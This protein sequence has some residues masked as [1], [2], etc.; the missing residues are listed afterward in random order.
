M[1]EGRSSGSG[2]CLKYQLQ[3]SSAHSLKEELGG[4]RRKERI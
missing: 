2:R 4:L 3:M 1:S